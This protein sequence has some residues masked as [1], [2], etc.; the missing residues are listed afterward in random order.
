[1]QAYAQRSHRGTN[2]TTPGVA[3]AAP[4]ASVA[5]PA[6]LSAIPGQPPVRSAYVLEDDTDMSEIEE[7]AAMELQE[8]RDEI[9]G[10]IPGDPE[11]DADYAHLRLED[12]VPDVDADSELT[13]EDGE[14][15]STE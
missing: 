2:R 11:P 12:D 8:A 5:A 13:F 7:A 6:A 14:R 4:A 3:A 10:A 9:L 1:G 15:P